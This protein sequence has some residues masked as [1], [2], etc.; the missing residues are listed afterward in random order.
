MKTP[1]SATFVKNLM[2]VEA[3]IKDGGEVI[4][5]RTPKN[6]VSVHLVVRRTRRRGIVG[7]GDMGKTLPTALNRAITEFNVRLHESESWA[8][9]TDGMHRTMRVLDEVMG[10]L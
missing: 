7:V 4:L 10:I 1:I 3:F 6:W 2:F 5:K 8:D 9:E